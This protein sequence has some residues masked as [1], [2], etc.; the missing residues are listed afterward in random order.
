MN[1]RKKKIR[2]EKDAEATEAADY[3]RWMYK[4]SRSWLENREEARPPTP[5]AP[6]EAPKPEIEKPPEEKPPG[7]EARDSEPEVEEPEVLE[8]PLE[9]T[10]RSSEPETWKPAEPAPEPKPEETKKPA[11]EPA[12]EVERG[13]HP[14]EEVEPALGSKEPEEKIE[15]PEPARRMKVRKARKPKTIRGRICMN[16]GY[17]RESLGRLGRLFHLLKRAFFRGETVGHTH[18]VEIKPYPSS[19]LE[20]RNLAPIVDFLY[21]EE[22]FRFLATYCESERIKGAK[23][24]RYFLEVPHQH[25]GLIT[26]RLGL[27]GLH[28]ESSNPPLIPHDLMCEM[29]LARDY[30]WPLIH[31]E[32][33]TALEQPSVAENI[34]AALC[35]GGTIGVLEVTAR[36]DSGSARRIARVAYYRNN[37]GPSLFYQLI[38]PGSAE[39]EQRRGSPLPEDVS[40]VLQARLRDKLFSCRVRI[41]AGVENV[42]S[43]LAALP[44]GRLNCL[45][46]CRSRRGGKEIQPIKKPSRNIA[47]RAL[48]YLVMLGALGLLGLSYI[49]GLFNPLRM[50]WLDWLVLVPVV[51]F[52][53]FVYLA[54]HIPRAIVL[55]TS[56]L[57]N[58]LSLPTNFGRLPVEFAKHPTS[59]ACPSEVRESAGLV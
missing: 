42:H 35:G 26:N 10:E 23:V 28:A 40:R 1:R 14:A 7:P 46:I 12:P 39:R 13:K 49:A 58:L 15:K 33:K 25:A 55:S 32:P 24:L 52:L 6:R 4:H 59:G 30:V 20:P 22:P 9:R 43:L 27:L 2:A 45:R 3:E 16:L 5:Q 57:S 8:R 47:K 50:G 34:A 18:W 44:A 19:K 36:A 51:V 37:P 31:T 48:K 41:Y 11:E 38:R 29:E 54:W 17:I 21:L 53:A 56:E